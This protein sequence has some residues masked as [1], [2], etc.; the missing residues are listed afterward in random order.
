MRILAHLSDLHFGRTRM[1]TLE[2]LLDVLAGVK[3]DVVAVSGDLTQRARTRE[4]RE[5]REFLDRLP[6]RVVVVPGNHDVPMHNPWVRFTQPL[7]KYRLHISADLDP[8]FEDEEIA[9]AGIN[10]ARSLTIKDG[11]VDAR[12][13]LRV[14]ERLRLAHRP[15]M[16][17]VVV[18]HHPFDLPKHYRD[19]D[20]V[21]R[22][23]LAM[24]HLAAAGV[25]LFLSGHFH[26]SH[27]GE[28]AARYNIAGHSAV[29]VQAGT[30]TSTRERG[31]ANAWNLIR[32][33]GR[34]IAVERHEW[35]DARGD[36]LAGEPLRFVSTEAG[37]TRA[38][39]GGRE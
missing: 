20:L 35:D 28:T 23:R 15:D 5:A 17:K 13:L 11:S 25:D 33:E 37:W 39:Q 29:F 30:A 24:V 34:S 26:V 21:G 19:A 32:T 22:A 27:V 36:F 9:V 10:T 31:E 12:Q 18:S 6:G 3:P 38:I 16:V 2:P 8:F 4:F 1:A 7:A 14:Q